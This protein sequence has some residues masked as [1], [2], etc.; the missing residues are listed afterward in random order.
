M[1][2]SKRLTKLF[3]LS[4]LLVLCSVLAAVV[5]TQTSKTQKQPKDSPRG[6]EVE[7]V[8]EAPEVKS[9]VKG[10]E[11][12]SVR[13]LNQGTPTVQIL[14]DVINHRDEDVMAADFICGV[15]KATS[16][17]LA[18]DGLQDLD[19]PRVIIP[20]HSLKTFEFFLSS[21]TEGE[22]IF[23]AA[24]TFSDGKEDGDPRSVSNFK[25]LR[26]HTQENFRKEKEKAKAKNGG[27]Q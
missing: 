22:S 7:K 23:L 24:A 1:G 19:N 27:P 14:I 10:V 6:W 18:M 9:A 2:N 4:T 5:Y 25:S 26:I 21:F 12:S 16:G 8:T 3:F 20:R 13:L 17:G 15:G 11:I